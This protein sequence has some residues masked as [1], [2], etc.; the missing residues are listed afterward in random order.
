MLLRGTDTFFLWCM[1]SENPDE[2]RL[3]HEVYADA[4]RYGRFLDKGIPVSFD[5][6]DQPGTVISGL[7][8]GDSVLVR[9]T[10]FSNNHDPVTILAGTTPVSVGYMPG[11]CEI[12][13]LK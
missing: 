13:S 9:R 2:V 1:E 12:I 5:L 7:A 3:L 11:R 6:P 4:Q 8:L 10:D